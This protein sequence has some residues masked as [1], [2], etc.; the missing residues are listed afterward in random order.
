MN[1]LA[2]ILLWSILFVL[3]WPLAMVVLLL[4]PVFW[5]LSLPFKLIGFAVTS[6]FAVV[7]LLLLLPFKVMATMTRSNQSNFHSI[8]A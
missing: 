3:C 1:V 7:M 4:W 6:V 5:L 2:T 8:N